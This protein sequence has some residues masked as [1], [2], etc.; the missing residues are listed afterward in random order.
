ML[1]DLLY[2]LSLSPALNILA[3]LLVMYCAELKI[4][5]EQLPLCFGFYFSLFLI[6]LL[7]KS[8]QQKVLHHLK[9]A[10]LQLS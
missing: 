1:P 7:K 2:H 4:N 5:H 9:R 10:R 3:D 6:L 8:H